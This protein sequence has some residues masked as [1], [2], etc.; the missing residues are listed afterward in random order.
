MVPTRMKIGWG[1]KGLDGAGVA[2]EQGQAARENI[3][4]APAKK[5]GA[6]IREFA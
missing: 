2:P 4:V 3:G 1:K 6:E 5:G